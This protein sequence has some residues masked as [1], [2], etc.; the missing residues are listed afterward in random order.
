MLN[1]PQNED[2]SI[3]PILH[4]AHRQI[5]PANIKHN[6]PEVVVS[7]SYQDRQDAIEATYDQQR[8]AIWDDPT[9]SKEQRQQAITTAW[10]QRRRALDNL[11]NEFWSGIG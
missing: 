4:N 9:L 2:D 3:V 8:Q 10:E 7:T 1:E 11:W 5:D 6:L